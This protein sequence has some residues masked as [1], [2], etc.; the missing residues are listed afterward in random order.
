M[1]IE[2]VA[3]GC[4]TYLAASFIV[5][6]DFSPRKGAK[7]I[8]VNFLIMSGGMCVVIVTKSVL[9]LLEEGSPL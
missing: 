3:S 2:A 5:L 7:K 9:S 4:F 6:K 8:G 1:I